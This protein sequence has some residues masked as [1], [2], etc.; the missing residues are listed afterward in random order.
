MRSTPSL[1][2]SMERA[3]ASEGWKEGSESVDA[4]SLPGMRIKRGMVSGMT[5]RVSWTTGEG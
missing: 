2:S 3:T 4:Q 1:E 5:A